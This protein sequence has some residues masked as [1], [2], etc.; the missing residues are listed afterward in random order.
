MKIGLDLDDVLASFQVKWLSFHNKVYKT[1]IK[2]KDVTCF[3]LAIVFDLDEQTV[4]KRIHEFYES[5]EFKSIK[6]VPGAVSSVK[7]LAKKHELFVVTARKTS[8]RKITEEWLFMHFG[9]IFNGIVLTNLASE[10]ASDIAVPKE[11]ACANLGIEIF[12]DDSPG[13][14]QKINAKGVKTLLFNKPWNSLETMPSSIT[15]VKSW[16]EIFS[17]I[18]N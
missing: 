17:L 9:K 2:Y 18:N 14:A 1:K 13:Y 16:R 10:N 15:R 4:W 8:L 12:V 7:A 6:P 5:D 3:N 11:V